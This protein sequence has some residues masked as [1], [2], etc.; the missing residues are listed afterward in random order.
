MVILNLTMASQWPVHVQSLLVLD[1]ELP[2]LSLCRN[3][4][5]V[6]FVFNFYGQANLQLFLSRLEDLLFLGDP[7]KD[8]QGC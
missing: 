4:F 2:F 7:V 8:I 3:V 1:V 5:F 6:V